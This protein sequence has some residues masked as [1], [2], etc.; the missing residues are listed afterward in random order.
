MMNRDYRDMVAGGLLM[1]VGLSAAIYASSHYSL[2]TI[3]RMGAGMMPTALGWIL[4]GF[5]AALVVGAFFRPGPL[6]EV[7]VFSAVLILGS[8]AAFGLVITPF[9]LLPAVV[10]STV[11]SS[12]AEREFKPIRLI[13]LSAALCVLAYLIFIFALRLPIPL[14]AW[15]F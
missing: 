8:V 14:F 5:G 10:A 7:R 3:T 15:P 9:G 12:L 4:A 11:V 1:A 2:G 13:A 6:P